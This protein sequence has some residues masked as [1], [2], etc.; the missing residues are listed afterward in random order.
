VTIQKQFSRYVIVGASSNGAIYML[1]LG[2]TWLG[3]GPKMAMTLLYILGVLQ[4]FF[5]NKSWSFGFS[6]NTNSAFVRYVSVYALGYVINYLAL[7]VLVDQM[8]LPHQWIMAGLVIV[9][10]ILFF[11][12]QKFW[13]FHKP[14]EEKGG[15]LEQT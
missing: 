8:G 12:L 1:Y 15:R 13:I 11:V 14:A 10:A 9:M 3:V 7:M 4:T 6:G 5:F 2:L